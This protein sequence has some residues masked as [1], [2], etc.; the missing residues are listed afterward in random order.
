MAMSHS[1]F[2]LHK[3]DLPF[4]PD[5]DPIRVDTNGAAKLLK[6]LEVHKA[7]GLDEISAQFFERSQRLSC[8]I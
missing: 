5:I 4:I 3:R 2:H 7:A 1:K 6:S 8:P